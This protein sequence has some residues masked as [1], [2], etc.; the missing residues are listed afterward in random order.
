MAGDWED[1]E[2]DRPGGDDPEGAV[3]EGA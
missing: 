2:P 1:T 3:E